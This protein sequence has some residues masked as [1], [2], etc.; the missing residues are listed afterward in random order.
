MTDTPNPLPIRLPPARRRRPNPVPSRPPRPQRTSS[1]IP[2]T[3]RKT[4]S[5]PSSPISAS[6]SSSPCLPR[7]I[8]PSPS[9]TRTGPAPAP[10]GG[11][12]WGRRLH[13]RRPGGIRDRHAAPRGRHVLCRPA[14]IRPVRRRCGLHDY[15]YHQ[16]RHRPNEAAS[17]HRKV[18]P[19]QVARREPLHVRPIR[20]RTDTTRTTQRACFAPRRRVAARPRRWPAPRPPR[21]VPPVPIVEG[22]DPDP[23]EEARKD[24]EENRPTACLA[25]IIFLL[26]LVFAPSPSSPATTPTRACSSPAAGPCGSSSSLAS[27]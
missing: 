17:D 4:R 24:A 22:P 26:P 13:R 2:P 3:W 12:H 10:D 16:R 19:H 9:T 20:L 21:L 8:H 18:H 25:Y 23:E 15:G 1:P 6:W 5:S 7:R 11:G 27:P 14:R